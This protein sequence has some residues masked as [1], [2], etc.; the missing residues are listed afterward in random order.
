MCIRDRLSDAALSCSPVKD[1][2]RA[3]ILK[4]ILLEMVKEE[5]EG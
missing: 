5:D 4:N 1:K 2:L 3:R